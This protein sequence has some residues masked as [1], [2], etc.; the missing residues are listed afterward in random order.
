[1]DPNNPVVQL[2][3]AG[4]QAE[5]EGSYET[6]RHLFQQAWETAQDHFEQCIAAHYVA[7][8]QPTPQQTLHWNEEA[9][10]HADAVTDGRVQGFYP[11][12]YL[13]LGHCHEVLGNDREAQRLY[14][15]AAAY[16]GTLPD[17]RYGNMVR[18][19]ANN[20]HDRLKTNNS[21]LL[22]SPG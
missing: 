9:L 6:A 13:N 21:G 18:R 15:L 8:H 4:M 12:L 10:R 5:G 20:G 22:D 2:C 1:M 17:D 14:D 19:G 11:S 16:A 3:V 7:R